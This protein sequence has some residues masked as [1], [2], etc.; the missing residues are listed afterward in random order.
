[1]FSQRETERAGTQTGPQLENSFKSISPLF[2]SGEPSSSLNS[3]YLW[4]SV[5]PH[6]SKETIKA[7]LHFH[8][9]KL[10]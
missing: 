4:L 5:T 1:M 2:S 9:N 3:F 8:I 10:K 6:R 7:I